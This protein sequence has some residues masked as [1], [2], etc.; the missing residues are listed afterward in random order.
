MRKFIHLVWKY[1]IVILVVV[2][3]V[4]TAVL[5]YNEI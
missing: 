4:C 3:A 2:M 1:A 5:I